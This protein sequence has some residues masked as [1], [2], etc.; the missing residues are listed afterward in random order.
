MAKAIERSIELA[1]VAIDA[2]NAEAR[3][4][5]DEAILL[6]HLI[7]DLRHYAAA[8]GHDFDKLASETREDYARELREG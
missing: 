5:G 2:F 6:W 1:R 8:H 3:L 4:E 7:L